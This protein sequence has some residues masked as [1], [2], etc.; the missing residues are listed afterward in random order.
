METTTRKNI[1][2]MV[3]FGMAKDITNA[4]YATLPHLDCVAKSFGVYGM[5]AGLFRDDAGNFYAVLARN[6]LLFQLA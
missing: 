2:N 4:E 6:S 5:N 3:A 1:K